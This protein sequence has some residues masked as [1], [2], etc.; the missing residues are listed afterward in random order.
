[1]CDIDGLS[2]EEALEELF[3]QQKA[4]TLMRADLDTLLQRLEDVVC[5]GER[6]AAVTMSAEPQPTAQQTVFPEVTHTFYWLPLLVSALLL[7]LPASLLPIPAAH[8]HLP[9]TAPSNTLRCGMASCPSCPSCP[10]VYPSLQAPSR[11]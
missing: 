7:A 6:Y 1:M 9:E 2:V 3:K 11:T 4:G 8:L 5:V 10:C